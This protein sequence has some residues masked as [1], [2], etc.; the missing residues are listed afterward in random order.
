MVLTELYTYIIREDPSYSGGD[1]D[2]KKKILK[3][4]LSDLLMKEWT[5]VGIPLVVYSLIAL[6]KGEEENGEAK[7]T[8]TKYPAKR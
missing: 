5:L 2:E 6:A 1:G 7:S 4:R 8:E 3:D